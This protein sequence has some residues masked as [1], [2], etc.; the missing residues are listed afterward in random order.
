MLGSNWFLRGEN[1]IVETTLR[2][3][4]FGHVSK[5]KESVPQNLDMDEVNSFVTAL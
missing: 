1:P 3:D 5:A 2:P 4:L